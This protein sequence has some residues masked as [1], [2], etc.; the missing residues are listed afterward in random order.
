MRS[1]AKTRKN[2]KS[3]IKSSHGRRSTEI[4]ADAY[5]W[6]LLA[7]LVGVPIFFL[8][9]GLDPINVP[10]LW[11][12]ASCVAFALS[13]RVLDL[14]VGSGRRVE[15]SSLWVPAAIMTSALVLAWV[16]SPIRGFTLIGEHGRFQGLLPYLLV[17]AFALLLRDAF[18]DRPREVVMAQLT[19]G[20]VIGAYAF[21]QWLGLDP[22]SWSLINETTRLS[23]STLGNPNFVG[24]FLGMLLPV[25]VAL[26]LTEQVQRDLLR[27]VGIPILL[28]WLV[29]GSEGGYVAGLTASL[30]VVGIVRWPGHRSLHRLIAAGVLAVVLGTWAVG[31][32]SVERPDS[33]IVPASVSV[34]AQW[35]SAAVGLGLESPIVGN[36]PNA[37]SIF[38]VQ[39]RTEF[40]AVA[41]GY[42][43]P[44]DPHSVP[45]SFLANSGTV[46]LLAFLGVIGYLSALGWRQRNRPLVVALSGLVLAYLIQGL[47]SIDE[48]SLRLLFWSGAAA[49][50][51]LVAEPRADG[52]RR[53]K[54]VKVARENAP[55]IDRPL[56]F[57]LIGAAAVILIGTF[58]FSTRLLVADSRAWAALTALREDRIDEGRS[59]MRSVLDLWSNPTYRHLFGFE[60]GQAA[61]SVS[62]NERVELLRES[63]GLFAFLRNLPQVPPM[64]DQARVLIQLEDEAALQRAASL[65]ERIVDLDGLNVLARIEMADIYLDLDDPGSA[66]AGL[67]PARSFADEGALPAYWGSLSLTYAQTGDF[68]AASEILEIAEAIDPN[69]RHVS[70]AREVLREAGAVE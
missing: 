5:R 7:G 17:F 26:Y 59:Q 49:L 57:A 16:F 46:G 15:V 22:F 6:I 38:G 9:T 37:F 25:V 23:T 30:V 27:R 70:E 44:D 42:E 54:K 33:G 12:L 60:I 40:D 67:E 4:L 29:A 43:F 28:G 56:G 36:G 65:Y 32:Y 21:I 1:L 13:V 48:L 55:T 31:V 61:S 66:L 50:V 34:R 35:W 63:D 68:E 19:S 18:R 11:L 20:A 14:V 41:F 47:V 8:R 64:R 53:S 69:E 10:K 52:Q 58:F 51:C 45:L 62:G 24:G 2:R 3:R 39:H